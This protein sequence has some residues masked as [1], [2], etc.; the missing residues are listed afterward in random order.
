MNTALA[1]LKSRADIMDIVGRYVALRAK[2]HEF[3]GLCPFHAES[4][5]SFKADRRQQRFICFGCGHKGDVLDFLAAA[6]GLDGAGAIRRLRE[7][8]GASAAHQMPPAPPPADKPSP[9]TGRNREL[10]QEVWRQT[11]GIWSGL[12]LPWR[13]LIERRGLTRWDHDRLRWHPRCPWRNEKAGCLVGPIND[14]ATGLVVGVWRILPT[15][16]GEVQRRGLGP[17][18]GNAARLFRAEGPQVVI[19]EGVEDAL[20]AHELTGLPAWAALSAGNMAELTLPRRLR[21][22]LILAD[23]DE[24][25]LGLAKA[26]ALAAR[27][28]QEGREAVVRRPTTG[29]DANDVLRTRRAA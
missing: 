28:R 9:G 13:Y 11:E 21:E 12:G 20:A 14:H 29:K 8:V 10:A 18:R 27:L 26:H 15:L 7:I 3:W 23:K 19:A 1:V 17:T 24:S 2:G 25:G 6:E 5:P 22:V 16:T 4:T